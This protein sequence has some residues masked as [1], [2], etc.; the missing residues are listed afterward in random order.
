MPERRSQV[1]FSDSQQP[2]ILAR[3][4]VREAINFS[5]WGGGGVIC[6]RIVL[7][8]VTGV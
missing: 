1:E 2:G 5:G 3:G 8:G 6:D 4:T 7:N